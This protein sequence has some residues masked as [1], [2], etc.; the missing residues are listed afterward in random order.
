M[1]ILKQVVL[2]V[3]RH[4]L[5][6]EGMLAIVVDG[7]VYI[8]AMVAKGFFLLLQANLLNME[9]EVLEQDGTEV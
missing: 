5:P 3:V 6:K 1:V 7:G 8:Q 9:A 2:V 4:Q